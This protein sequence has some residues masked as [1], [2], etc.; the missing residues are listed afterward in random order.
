MKIEL[1][2]HGY[3]RL[4]EYM[5]SDLSVVRAA[6]VSYN[7]AWRVGENEGSDTRLLRFLWS[8]KHTS[9]FEAVALTFEVKA[10]IF[11]L[12]QWHR[13]RTQSY[14]EMSARYCELPEEFYLPDPSVVGEQSTNNKQGRQEAS[15]LAM[16]E[17]PS[18]VAV[19]KHHCE[20]AFVLYRDLLDKGWP[21]E[22][23][24]MC[25]PLNTYSAMF[26]TMNLLNLFRFATLRLDPHAQLEIRVYAR[27][28]I[29]LARRVAPICVG[30]WE[31]ELK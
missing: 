18:Q 1:L 23:A 15:V 17:R 20:D 16:S 29:E 6:R 4:V 2:D 26:A 14:N 27:A 9:P 5:G 31:E 21:R 11:V 3:V 7:A 13:H 30:A 28:M 24:R 22:L 8:H 19:L 25:L 10:P 12:R